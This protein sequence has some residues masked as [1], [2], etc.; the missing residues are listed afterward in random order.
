M[1]STNDTPQKLVEATALAKSQMQIPGL[2]TG[3]TS[4]Q[5]LYKNSTQKAVSFNDQVQEVLFSRDD[6][7]GHETGSMTTKLS[8]VPSAA[9][10]KMWLEKSISLREMCLKKTRDG[11][12]PACVMSLQ[13][14]ANSKSIPDTRQGDAT[15]NDD[16]MNSTIAA[17]AKM[18]LSTSITPS[19]EV[20]VRHLLVGDLYFQTIEEIEDHVQHRLSN[21]TFSTDDAL[22]GAIEGLQRRTKDKL[23][24]LLKCMG[25]LYPYHGQGGPCEAV[26]DALQDK[27]WTEVDAKADALFISCATPWV[28]EAMKD[29]TEKFKKKL[30]RKTRSRIC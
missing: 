24:G 19:S 29:I 2:R 7:I 22:R 6:V 1:S 3:S 30:D 15:E 14:N 16:E 11:C 23:T 12:M 13:Q 8:G 21:L 27:D 9:W 26:A 17:F 18:T 20:R 25:I 5:V 28:V 4:N 10:Q